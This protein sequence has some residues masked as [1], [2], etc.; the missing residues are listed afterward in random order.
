MTDLTP[1]I[2]AY[3]QQRLL[4]LWSDLPFTLPDAPPANRVI[5]I[6]RQ[7]AA[8]QALPS[9]SLPPAN[10]PPLPL[11]SLDPTPR[12]Q[13]ALAAA[14]APPIVV[15]SRQAVPGRGRF[16]LLQLAGDL[17]SRRGLILSRRDLRDLSNDT[18]KRYLLAE[19]RRGVEGGALLVVGAD[20][21]HP[22]FAA[23]WSLVWP[24]LGQPPAYVLGDPA[25][26]WPA[27]LTPLAVPFAE[28][29]AQLAAV[30]PTPEAGA[31]AFD[32]DG[33][34]QLIATHRRRL[35]KLQQQQAYFGLDTRPHILMEIEDIT[36]QIDA[37]EADLGL[38][39]ASAAPEPPTAPVQGRTG[40]PSW[41]DSGHSTPSQPPPAQVQGR[42]GAQAFEASEHSTPSQPPPVRGRSQDLP[43]VGGTEGG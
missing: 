41:Q 38:P 42:T 21:T 5:A 23:W 24:G 29:A 6:N 12:L 22:D 1:L 19:A 17:P 7:I 4:L 8:A 37:L 10:L 27:G 13:Q 35:Q 32:P 40:R 33:V 26:D 11:L 20:P 15:A 14:G 43:P 28:L 39:P 31:P 9:L 25:A 18:D 16:S 3:Q 36:D 2:A 30:E 34:K